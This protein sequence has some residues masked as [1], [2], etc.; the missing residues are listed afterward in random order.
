MQQMIYL[1]YICSFQKEL[2]LPSSQLLGL[3]NRTIR[4][5]VQVKLVLVLFCA[6]GLSLWGASKL[7]ERLIGLAKKATE[8][9]TEEWT[10]ALKQ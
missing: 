1:M 5:V 2:E 6:T 3:F 4:K 10:I 7:S 9:T 8:Q